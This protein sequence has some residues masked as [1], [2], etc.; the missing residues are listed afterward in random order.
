MVMGRT[1]E[2]LGEPYY[3]MGFAFSHAASAKAEQ[4][5]AAKVY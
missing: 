3:H 2:A 5:S 1:A 4:L